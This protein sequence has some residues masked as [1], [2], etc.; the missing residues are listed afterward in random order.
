M[1][2]A[3]CVRVYV[4]V[5]SY[6]YVCIYV[7]VCVRVCVCLCACVLAGVHM[8]VAQNNCQSICIQNKD[9]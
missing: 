1:C 9:S 3:M 8:C 5:C 6:V 2:V 4:C 7:C